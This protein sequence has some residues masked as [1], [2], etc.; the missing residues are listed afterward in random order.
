MRTGLHSVE[1]EPVLDS[2]ESGC[3][4]F[5]AGLEHTLLSI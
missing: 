2:T 1:F 3:G 4:Y 5:I